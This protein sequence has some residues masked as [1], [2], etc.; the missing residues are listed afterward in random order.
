MDLAVGV[1]GH[2]AGMSFGEHD[3]RWRHSDH[4]RLFL[5]DVDVFQISSPH[6][7]VPARILRV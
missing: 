1:G 4:R 5:I 6:E 3:V 7:I 2:A